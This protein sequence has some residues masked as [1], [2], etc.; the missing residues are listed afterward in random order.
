VRVLPVERVERI[1]ACLDDRLSI[2]ETSR[3]TETAQR[4]VARYAHQW[5]R[6]RIRG[7]EVVDDCETIAVRPSPESLGYFAAGAR[8][9][10]LSRSQ[11]IHQL[12]EAIAEADLVG[13]IL[14]DAGR[15]TL[16]A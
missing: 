15:V 13:S 9:R 16:N 7:A 12:L 4:T 10:N 1:F 6:A 3:R 5:R 2:R 8:R 14:G 11:L